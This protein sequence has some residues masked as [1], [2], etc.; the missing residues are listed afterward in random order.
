MHNVVVASFYGKSLMQFYS[1]NVHR[2]RDPQKGPSRHN[3]SESRWNTLGSHK[4]LFIV[5]LAM[6]PMFIDANVLPSSSLT[7][8]RVQDVDCTK[9]ERVRS[10]AV[11][12]HC[13]DWDQPM[14]N[15][16]R[17]QEQQYGFRSKSAAVIDETLHEA[18]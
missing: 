6:C 14:D 2:V 16:T 10:S 13:T 7:R 3:G 17:N 1:G 12:Q 5:G 8:V 18:G 11:L 15:E 9:L 4:M